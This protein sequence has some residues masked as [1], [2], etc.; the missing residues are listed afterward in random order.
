MDING[1]ERIDIKLC[2]FDI[3]YY[4]KVSMKLTC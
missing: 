2:L 4:T 1:A 3:K